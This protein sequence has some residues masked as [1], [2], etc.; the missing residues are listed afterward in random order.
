MNTE[1][2]AFLF[3]HLKS[4]GRWATRVS[5][6]KE[7]AFTEL[8]RMATYQHWAGMSFIASEVIVI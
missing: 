5:E 6:V 7:G 3:F 8:F 4:Q 1:Y 2:L